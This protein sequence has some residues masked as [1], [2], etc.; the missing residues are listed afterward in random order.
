METFYNKEDE[1]Y[2]V[3][4]IETPIQG[5]VVSEV[6]PLELLSYI[7][8]DRYLWADKANHRALHRIEDNLRLF[9]STFNWLENQNI[10]YVID[11][12]RMFY[13]KSMQ[14]V[15]EESTF[16]KQN[17]SAKAFDLL[18]IAMETYVLGHLYEPIFLA[19]SSMSSTED[20]SLNKVTRNLLHINEKQLGIRREFRPSVSKAI[21]IINEMTQLKTPLDKLNCL[22][23][24][25]N[26]AT[27]PLPK[28]STFEPATAD[29]LIPILAFLVIRSEQPNWTATIQY[30]KN[31]RISAVKRPEF[32]AR[33]SA[34][35]AAVSYIKS[36]EIGHST[37]LPKAN[38]M[39]Y[40]D[41]SICEFFEAV[42][43]G[44]MPLIQKHLGPQSEKSSLNSTPSS[45][46]KQNQSMCHPLCSCDKCLSLQSEDAED[47]YP[48]THRVLSRSSLGSVTI[49]FQG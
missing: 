16:R 17:L 7:D 21:A 12:T 37:W 34:L 27:V 39:T 18:K 49:F 4:C 46:T 32:D 24:A 6:T 20:I 40:S 25:V 13:T 11:A 36:E 9:D 15:L 2:P 19:L 26:V 42:S 14:I 8:C 48:S 43:S 10:R 28:P 5:K 3:L 22:I 47:A 30:M 38:I 35:E 31:F 41:G 45:N 1:G 23:S 44:N 29:D 33:L